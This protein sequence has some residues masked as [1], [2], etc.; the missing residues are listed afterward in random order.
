MTCSDLCLLFW[1]NFLK[2][3][4]WAV[5]IAPEDVDENLINQA[6]YL[7]EEVSVLHAEL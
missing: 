1:P 4:S 6:G 3:D 2:G 5:Q 7:D